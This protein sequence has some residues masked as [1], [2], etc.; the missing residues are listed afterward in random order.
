MKVL[1]SNLRNDLKD[2][3]FREKEV[4][5]CILEHSLAFGEQKRWNSHQLKTVWDNY[6]LVHRIL[7]Q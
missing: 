5:L 3:D 1:S 4:V 2:L 7:L 6:D